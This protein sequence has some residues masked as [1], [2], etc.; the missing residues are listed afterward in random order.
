M[1]K[2]QLLK[3]SDLIAIRPNF[4]FGEGKRDQIKEQKATNKKGT[5]L[6]PFLF[7]LHPQHK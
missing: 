6:Q 4:F 2:V 3:V 1:P 5:I 7:V